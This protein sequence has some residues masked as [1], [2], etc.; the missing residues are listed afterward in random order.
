MNCS[1]QLLLVSIILLMSLCTLSAQSL[2]TA[3]LNEK[4][5]FCVSLVNQGRHDDALFLLN[6]FSHLNNDSVLFW[7]G[8]TLLQLKQTDSAITCFNSIIKS[9]D[10]NELKNRAILFYNHCKLLTFPDSLITFSIDTNN[11]RKELYR[12][13]LLAA[14]LIKQDHK[15]FEVEFA[16]EKC[17]FTDLAIIEFNLYLLDY[18]L[19][20]QKRKKPFI[21][22]ILSAFIP[23][24]G[25]VYAG[26]P[27]E[28]LTAFLPVAF[29]GAQ[30]AEGYYHR[31]LKSPHLYVF[32]AIGS[33]FYFS[34]IYGSAK[35]AS[36]SNKEKLEK[37]RLKFFYELDKLPQKY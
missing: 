13:Q 22:G 2:E 28:A 6:K 4:L 7:K 29:N 37:V 20:N 15:S 11:Y 35:S 31:Q 23:G 9:S 21:A 32:G 36:R 30:A 1:R 25:K 24:S 14:Y 34:N 17:R 10:N 16:K 12:I 27:H 26:K 18:E 8:Y 5:R 3:T 19:K 33:V